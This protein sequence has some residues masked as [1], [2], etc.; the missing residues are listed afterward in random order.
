VNES[1]RK[2]GEKKETLS[3]RRKAE[4]VDAGGYPELQ[5]MYDRTSMSHIQQ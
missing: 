1:G 2:E 4:K 3:G 5:L